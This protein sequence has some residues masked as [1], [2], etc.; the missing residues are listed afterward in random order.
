MQYAMH[1]DRPFQKI[2]NNV[3]TEQ[4]QNTSVPVTPASRDYLTPTTIRNT[5]LFSL[6]I[7]II[8]IEYVSSPGR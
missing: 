1:K 7:E 3:I 8:H 6:L 4:R 2:Q 5:A